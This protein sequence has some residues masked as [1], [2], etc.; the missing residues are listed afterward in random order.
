MLIIGMY[1]STI[2]ASYNKLA[3]DGDTAIVAGGSRCR[4]V[5]TSIFQICILSTGTDI[6]LREEEKERDTA[7]GEILV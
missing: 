7:W 6:G 2:S 5:H 4:H 3:V 1:C